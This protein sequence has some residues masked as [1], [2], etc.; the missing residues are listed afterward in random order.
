MQVQQD[1][2]TPSRDRIVQELQQQIDE[3]KTENLLLHEQIARKE[4]FMAMIA[5]D[6]RTP[7]TPILNYA[8][9]LARQCHS[10]SDSEAT[11]EKKNA[12]IQ[13][14]TSIIISQAHRMNRQVNDLLDISHLSINQFALIRA[15]HD[16]VTLVK[17]IV[18]YARPVAPYHTIVLKAPETSLIGNW[19]AGRLQQALGNLLD[20]A[21]KYS[22]EDTTITV[23]VSATQQ[24]AQVS[25]HNQGVGIPSSD[26]GL[27]FRP[28]TRLES[29][30]RRHGTGLGL[31]IAK[32]II[33]AHGGTL[34]LEPR[35][36]D[37]SQEYARGTTF[38]FELP[39]GE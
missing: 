13:R 37:N 1:K 38:T 20:N 36:E 24:Y 32:S 4:Q 18:E 12:A 19:D 9:L 7:L 6:L 17:E 10:S 33:E 30:Q 15:Q 16:L 35:N 25:I 31:F 29:S 22:G 23:T 11:I 27:L 2:T 14:Q 34:R 28:Y 5:H 39:L 26:I 8:Q 21:I 3:L